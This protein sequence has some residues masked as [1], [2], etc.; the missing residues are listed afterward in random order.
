MTAT[1]PPNYSLKK[2]RDLCENIYDEQMAFL[3]M[4]TLPEFPI[5]IVNKVFSSAKLNKPSNDAGREWADIVRLAFIAFAPEGSEPA[6]LRGKAIPRFRSGDSGSFSVNEKSFT[7]EPG[8]L[9]L[10][11]V[12]HPSPLLRDIAIALGVDR[13]VIKC[14]RWLADE[15]KR[16]ILEAHNLSETDI[17]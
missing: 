2:L 11:P 1:P 17:V 4:A 15:L 8:S 16:Q 6:K 12:A 14:D 13:F 10:H 3:L 7:D 5:E 9:T